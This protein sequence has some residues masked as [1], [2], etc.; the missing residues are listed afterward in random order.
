MLRALRAMRSV[1]RKV[2][3]GEFTRIADTKNIIIDSEGLCMYVFPVLRTG[4]ELCILSGTFF[5]LF[6]SE[7]TRCLVY[8]VLLGKEESSKYIHT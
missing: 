6:L 3:L 5:F 1:F 7:K 4:P 2:A 8:K